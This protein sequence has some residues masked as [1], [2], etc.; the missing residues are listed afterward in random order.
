MTST[1]I[2]K[3]AAKTSAAADKVYATWE[4]G[5]EERSQLIRVAAYFIAEREGF[6]GDE[7]E[8][9]AAAEYHVNQMLALRE[10]QE[11]LQIVIDTALDAVVMMDSTGT[12]TSWSNLAESIFGWLREEAV[13]RTLHETI[14]PLRYH[15]SHLRGMKQFLATGEGRILN[16]RI[17]AYARHRDGHEF[18]VE[19]SVV[20]IK[21][22]EKFEFSAFIRDIS[23]RK[24]LEEKL[25]ESEFRYRT[26]ADF[27]SD[28]EYWM[29]PDG[30]LRY[31]SPS[32]EQV[33]G[34]TPDEFNT[35]PEL[36]TRIV[37]PDDLHLYAG[38][39]H[40][41]SAQGM[42]EPFDYRIRTKD[43]GYRWISHVCRP[44]YDPAGAPL[45]HRA[46]NR[47][48]TERKQ[49]EDQV[50]QLAF[51]DT[52]TELPNRRLL[53]DR[54]SQSLAASKRHGLYGALMFLDLDNFKSLNDTHGHKVGDLLLIEAANRLKNCVREMDTVAR[55]GGDEFVVMISE[56]DVDKLKSTAQAGSIAEKLSAALAMPYVLKVQHEGK[57]ETTVEHSCTAS[58][59]VALF[60]KDDATQEDILKWADMAMY[61]AKEAS[62]N[63]IRF[64]AGA[65]G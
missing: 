64:Y 23:E 11:K 19:L 42:P 35:D 1:D 27:T 57:A 52:L 46:S 49:M 16:C 39:V 29:M 51:H 61:Q 65:D 6:K 13:G 18:P 34:Y 12:I 56:L 20:P 22:R 32:C 31:I 41:L 59:G 21:L 40:H 53:S 25:R 54:L 7:A 60:S 38:H 55:F 30:T 5:P 43:D 2:R 62:C 48:I 44:V 26:V 28:W 36:L 45:G 15:E 10:S 8:H 37:H 58:I 14:I 9:W 50:R 3:I 47:D 33:S 4:P 63:L 24:Q 17:E